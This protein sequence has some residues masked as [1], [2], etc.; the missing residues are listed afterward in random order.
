MAVKAPRASAINTALVVCSGSRG[1]ADFAV[2]TLY[3]LEIPALREGNIIHLA[4]TTLFVAEACS[5][6][7]SLMALITIGVMVGYLFSSSRVEWVLIVLSAIP[8]AILLNA[9][10]VA[11]T[12]LLTYRWGE[13][14]AAGLLHQ[15]EGMVMF[16]I[17]FLLLFGEAQLLSKL[18]PQRLRWGAAGEGGLA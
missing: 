17:A 3:L 15:T 11:L 4:S 6:L 10:R 13:Q 8:I 12:G 14:A 2:N 5:G 9:V 18:W 16:G 7:R 1:P